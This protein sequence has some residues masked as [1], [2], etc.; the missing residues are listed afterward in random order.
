MTRTH[1]LFLASFIGAIALPSAVAG[2]ASDKIAVLSAD[3][4]AAKSPY[5]LQIH[6]PDK[7]ADILVGAITAD[8][9]TGFS[10]GGTQPL[11]FAFAADVNGDGNDEVVLVREWKKKKGR[12]ELTV[13]APPTE[14]NGSMGKV[15]ASSKKKSLGTA[16]GD[17]AITAMAAIDANG[18]GV[19]EVMIARRWDDGRNS[20]EIRALP[21]KKKA[22]LGALI[23]SDDNFGPTAQELIG[24]AAADVVPGE[25]L[26]EVVAL[27]RDAN[28]MDRLYVYRAP[29]G[30]GS[31]IGAPYVFGVDVSIVG[32]TNS[33]IAMID[34]ER[35]GTKELILQ[36][37][38]N[39]GYDRLDVV[40][41][42]MV[43][44]FGTYIISDTLPDASADA[45]FVFGLDRPRVLPPVAEWEMYAVII[46][47]I[48]GGVDTQ[49]QFVADV[50]I[51]N[52]GDGTGSLT[53]PD[54]EVVPMTLPLIASGEVT[55]GNPS[56][57]SLEIYDDLLGSGSVNTELPD[58]TA[59][60]L[61]T[62]TWIRTNYSIPAFG[63]QPPPIGQLN[64]AHG[65]KPDF[66]AVWFHLKE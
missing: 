38:M 27:F 7:D 56:P 45:R 57:I 2:E 5:H 51:V 66:N 59:Q 12:L 65:W 48:P 43:S 37:R 55:F 29:F 4:L 28:G 36:R 16:V 24:L 58:A 6:A 22:P 20:V 11:R 47:V 46:A 50:S 23:A 63:T 1:A 39:S 18:D 41:F 49:S 13:V 8:S 21:S 53:L 30:P 10:A 17:G 14:P 26:D 61:G 34:L 40:S 31:T 3:A 15:L 9:D 62:G 42:D 54:G 33:A 32:A 19:D 44:G 35:D 52:S 64:F 25:G 60:W